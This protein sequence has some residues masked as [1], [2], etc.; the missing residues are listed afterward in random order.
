M[1]AADHGL[2]ANGLEEAFERVARLGQCS[3]VGSRLR[4]DEVGETRREWEDFARLPSPYRNAGHVQV[5][6]ADGLAC[7]RG[8]GLVVEH[9][10]DVQLCPHR[11]L[12]S[13]LSG[14]AIE[15]DGIPL[16]NAGPLDDLL[17]GAGKRRAVAERSRLDGFVDH[18]ERL[19]SLRRIGVDGA[20][21]GAHEQTTVGG[22]DLVGPFADLRRPQFLAVLRCVCEHLAVDGLVLLLTGPEGE[23]NAVGGDD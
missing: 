16:L 13:Q 8:L 23:D 11:Q 7:G 9:G 12:A 1:F 4:G 19:H 6:A 2:A 5:R 20:V 18:A 22:N 15:H 10:A 3:T 14:R 21:T 17:R